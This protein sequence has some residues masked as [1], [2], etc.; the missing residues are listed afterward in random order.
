MMDMLSDL[1][2]IILS[3]A[4]VSNPMSNVTPGGN[5]KVPRHS[6]AQEQASS[7]PAGQSSTLLPDGH[8]LHMGGNGSGGI[9]STISMEDPETHSARI[10]EAHL[11]RARSGH[12]ATL[13]PDGTVLILGG[14]GRDGDTLAEAESF[15]PQTGQI[16]SIGRFGLTPRSYSTATLLT[17][18]R[19]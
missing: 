12:T 11:L 19:L 17:D 14:L 13:L 8:I 3:V 2:R 9:Q 15:D 10:L 16:E 4:V 1:L 18:G 6:A 5:M 7:T